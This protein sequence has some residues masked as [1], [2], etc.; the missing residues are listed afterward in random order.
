MSITILVFKHQ[1]VVA[2]LTGLGT[3]VIVVVVVVIVVIVVVIVLIVVVVVVAA[4]ITTTPTVRS[5]WRSGLR[6]GFEEAKEPCIRAGLTLLCLSLP[7]L[8]TS[9]AHIGSARLGFEE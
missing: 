4:T 5:G 9:T 3:V 1:L 2:A 8:T 6:L 7:S